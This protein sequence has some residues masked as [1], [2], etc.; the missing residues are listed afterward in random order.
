M[1]KELNNVPASGLLILALH[2]AVKDK[3][4]HVCY[5]SLMLVKLYRE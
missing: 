5:D 3:A 1:I 4:V 2:K